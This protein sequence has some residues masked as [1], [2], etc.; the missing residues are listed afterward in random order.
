MDPEFGEMQEMSQ[1]EFNTMWTG[2]LILAEPN[3]YFEAKNERVSRFRRFAALIQPHRAILFQS[4]LG[5]IVYT[6]LGL[7]MAIYIQK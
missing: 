4:L 7:S 3:E 5:A 6:V 2:V 1:E